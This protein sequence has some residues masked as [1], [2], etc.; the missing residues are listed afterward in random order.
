[1][2]GLAGLKSK[3]HDASGDRF[4]EKKRWSEG[5][6]PACLGLIKPAEKKERGLREETN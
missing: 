4:R 5:K 3:Q 2:H 6:K 1:L